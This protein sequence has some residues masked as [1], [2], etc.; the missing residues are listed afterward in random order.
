MTT[1]PPGE[2]IDGLDEP[3]RSDIR[4]LHGYPTGREG[5]WFRVGWPAGKQSIS[6][7][8]V[9]EEDGGTSRRRGPLASERSMWARAASASC[10]WRT[11][12]LS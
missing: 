9:A 4:E 8:V 2:Y 7:Y 6:L 11:L 3:R 1:T 10:G 12:G 5:D